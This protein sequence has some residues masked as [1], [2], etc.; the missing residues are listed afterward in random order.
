MKTGKITTKV[1]AILAAMIC[2]VST[3]GIGTTAFAASPDTS[4]SIV[5]SANLTASEREELSNYIK[6]ISSQKV[7]AANKSKLSRAYNDNQ[8]LSSEFNLKDNTLTMTSIR[9]KSFD[10]VRSDF[11]LY[12]SIEHTAYPG[13]LIKIDSNFANG[14]PTK[15]QVNRKDVKYSITCGDKKTFVANPT[16][17]GDVLEEI[18]KVVKG[19]T[20]DTAALA[21]INFSKVVNQEQIKAKL[22]ISASLLKKLN[23]NF[24]A[25]HQGKEITYIM[26]F[27]Q[28]YF[29]VHMDAPQNVMDLFADSADKQSLI[30]AGVSEDTPIGYVSDVSYGREIYVVISSKNTKTSIEALEE[31]E[32][33]NFDIKAQQSWEKI[34]KSCNVKAFVRGG[35]SESITEVAKIKDYDTFVSAIDKD[36]K[37]T[38]D[39]CY[40]PVGYRVNYV[41]T[42]D[43]VSTKS[44]GNYWEIA[45]KRTTKGTPLTLRLKDMSGSIGGSIKSGTFVITG[46]Y[47]T[48]IDEN[49]NYIHGGQYYDRH[50]YENKDLP[51][52]TERITIP[53]NVDI[54]TVKIRFDY[55]GTC[56]RKFDDDTFSVSNYRKEKKDS[57]SITSLVVELEG[58]GQ[59]FG[60]YKVEGRAWVNKAESECT[61]ENTAHYC[62]DKGARK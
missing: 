14:T 33:V 54:E 10:E 25:I 50:Y 27:K 32:G 21:D 48:G 57:S 20:S 29:N 8:P 35:R 22:D 30:N 59:G 4:V 41:G 43:I 36:A 13:A 55:T 15:V 28:S 6:L 62:I 52:K 11:S 31:L 16:N 40:V 19:S 37:F 42:N 60:F 38:S 2:A 1:T 45:S 12:D 3:V 5:N 46:D 44:V 18:Y 17:S 51:N 34:M 23:V 9:K 47:I 39:S 49:G 26:S 58:T 61:K 53:A 24:E 7:I 56:D